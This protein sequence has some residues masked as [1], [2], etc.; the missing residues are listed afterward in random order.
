MVNFS[1]PVTPAIIITTIFLIFV[2]IGIGI[3]GVKKFKK[4][5]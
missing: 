3:F 5:S 1:E 2:V 4:E